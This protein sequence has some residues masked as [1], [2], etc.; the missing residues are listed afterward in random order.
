MYYSVE[1]FKGKKLLKILKKCCNIMYV[2]YFILVLNN[3]I[4]IDNW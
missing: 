2:L 3:S 1:L 4:D